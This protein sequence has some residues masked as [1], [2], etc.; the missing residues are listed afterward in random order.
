MEMPNASNTQKAPKLSAAAIKAIVDLGK[1]EGIT[2]LIT[3]HK[4]DLNEAAEWWKDNGA[5]KVTGYQA[6][7]FDR[8]V[9]GPMSP[10]ELKK[11]LT[12]TGSKNAVN[13]L[14]QWDNIRAMA[15]RI[16][17]AKASKK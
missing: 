15:N 17:D 11:F 13:H 12:A 10:E 9:E 14:K 2:K 16:W 7:L 5:R 8:L 3:E 1:N 6:Q 4:M